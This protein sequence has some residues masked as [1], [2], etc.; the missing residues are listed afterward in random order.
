[1]QE[2]RV[3]GEGETVFTGIARVE[4]LAWAMDEVERS[5]MPE[6]RVPTVGAIRRRMEQL[7][8]DAEDAEKHN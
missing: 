3:Q 6:P 7:P 1:M 4:R 5:R 2:V 8:R